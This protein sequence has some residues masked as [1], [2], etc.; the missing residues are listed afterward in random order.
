MKVGLVQMGCKIDTKDNVAKTT[1]LIEDAAKKGAEIV[2]L[3]ELFN[4]IYFAYEQDP[5]YFDWAE[6]VPGG[7][8]FKAMSAAAQKNGVALVVPMFERDTVVPGLFYNTTAFFD[9][10]GKY[11]GKYR[12]ASL[13]QLP[14]YMEKFYFSPGNLGYP[15]FELG[16]GGPKVAT[17]TCYDRHFLEGPRIEALKG[18]QIIFIPTCTSFYPE[19]WELELRAHA[20][21]NTVFVAGVNRCGAEYPGQSRAYYGTS[22]VVDPTGAVMAK[23]GEGDQVLVVDVPLNKLEERRRMAPFLRDRRPELYR[24]IGETPKL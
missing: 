4:T 21:F 9:S 2:C 13:P 7:P 22:M 15:V 18:A 16:E 1:R 17:V 20:S 12:K 3:Q 6:P 8:T 14:G 10:K 24:E 19:L 5:K 23:A 11:L